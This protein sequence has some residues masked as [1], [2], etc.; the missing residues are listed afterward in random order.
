MKKILVVSLSIILLFMAYLP[1]SASAIVPDKLC[2]Y[3]NYNGEKIYYYKNNSG[4][5]YVIENG[6][7]IP[8]AVPVLIERINDEEEINQLNQELVANK[9]LTAISY[10]NLPYSKTMNFSNTDTTGILHVTKSYIF[11]KCSNLNPSGATRGFSYYVRFSPDGTTWYSELY[12]NESLLV[13]TRHNW[14]D[15]GNSPYIKIQMWSYYG[16]VSSCTLNVRESNLF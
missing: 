5:K 6:K 12:I 7:K 2:Y 10:V 14:S 11:L 9:M 13:Y 8:I 15:F 16:T 4:E 1:L 3:E